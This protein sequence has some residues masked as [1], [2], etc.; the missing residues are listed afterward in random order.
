[1]ALAGALGSYPALLLALAG[2]SL[3]SVAF[4]TGTEPGPK[5]MSRGRS[6]GKTRLATA[7]P[8]SLQLA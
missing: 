6:W 5:I 1:M 3:I 8:S 2:T 7:C 4:M